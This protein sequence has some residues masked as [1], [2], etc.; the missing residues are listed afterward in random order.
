MAVLEDR[1]A[2]GEAAGVQGPGL[3]RRLR[4]T[5]L[6]A[7]AARGEAEAEAVKDELLRR[8]LRRE[9]KRRGEV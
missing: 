6:A 9:A 7:Y 5:Q 4:E 8:L 1:L 3:L 2:Q